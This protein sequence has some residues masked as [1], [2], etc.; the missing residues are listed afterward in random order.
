MNTFLN[1]TL[2]FFGLSLK[3]KDESPVP[4]A[5]NEDR[6]PLEVYISW[7]S[8]VKQEIKDINKR[9]SRTFIIIAVFVS[10]L[11]VAMQEFGLILVVASLI[12]FLFAL[13]KMPEQ[14]VKVEVNSHGI[15]YGDTIYFWPDL[16]YFFFK[17]IGNGEILI[18]DTKIYIPGRLFFSFNAED[19]EKIKESIKKHIIFLEQEPVSYMDKLLNNVKSRFNI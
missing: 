19:K 10:L 2:N 8:V 14:S 18:V 12:F 13:N 11:L 3:R 17:A 15:K 7:D 5:E 6:G 9:F 4:T 16:K 1:K